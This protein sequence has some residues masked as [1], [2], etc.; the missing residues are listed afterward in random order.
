MA[1]RQQMAKEFRNMA[2][3]Y[4]NELAGNPTTPE[5]F[6]RYAQWGGPNVM[7]PLNGSGFY[8]S[9]GGVN[10]ARG[11]AP[12]ESDVDKFIRQLG[13]NPYTGSA[14]TRRNTSGGGSSGNVARAIRPGV[15]QPQQETQESILDQ[16]AA[17]FKSK[18]NEANAANLARYD[19]G[20]GELSTLR[21]R[22]QGRVE[23][24]GKAASEDID[25]RMREALGDA[26]ANLAA[27]GL[28]NSNIL[29]A[30]RLRAARDTAREQ[31]RV[32]E[33]RDSRASQYD[34]NDTNNLVGFIERRNDIAPDYGQLIGLADRIGQADALKAFQENMAAER[35]QRQQ[36]PQY[37]G[38]GGYGGFGPY[39][40][41]IP[42]YGPQGPHMRA[43]AFVNLFGGAMNSLPS[44]PAPVVS[45]AYP[46]V[47][48]RPQQQEPQP[49][50]GMRAPATPSPSLAPPK[51]TSEWLG[52]ELRIM[53]LE[54][55]VAQTGVLA[56]RLD[57]LF[58]NQ[59]R[60]RPTYSNLTQR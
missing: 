60:M 13:G 55:G 37:G 42:S 2:R 35:A 18:I 32:S 44:G 39:G 41:M 22:N 7:D 45:N 47:N 9:S 25:E 10:V 28:G 52:N 43:P 56:P 51:V 46:T 36:T 26:S 8:R 49:Y 16:L 3:N 40:P 33:M 27:R 53:P 31:Q 58:P 19:E 54:A 48:Q 57:E 4:L 30:F 20:K 17:E 34:T 5:D 11:T 12:S 23:N 59:S 6:A 14:S 15:P 50:L 21:D 24:W 38:Y 29:D 1:T